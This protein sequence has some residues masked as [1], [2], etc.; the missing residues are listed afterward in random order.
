[1][2]QTQKRFI[3][4]L[5]VCVMT[6][7]NFPAAAFAEGLEAPAA[8]GAETLEAVIGS[9]GQA[10]GQDGSDTA[11][12]GAA[13]LPDEDEEDDEFTP[14]GDDKPLVLNAQALAVGVGQTAEL[15]IVDG[16]YG[17]AMLGIS[18]EATGRAVAV[19]ASEENPLSCQIRGVEPGQ[20]TV[21]VTAGELTATCTVTVT[22]DQEEEPSAGGDGGSG[23]TTGGGVTAPPDEE[24]DPGFTPGEDQKPL[25]LDH[26]ELALS[27]GEEAELNVVDGPYGVAAMGIAFESSN[28]DVAVAA[29]SEENPLSAKIRGIAEGRAVITVTAGKLS[30]QCTV[31]VEPANL[32]AD[33]LLEGENHA[34]Y[35]LLQHYKG[36][37]PDSYYSIAALGMLGEDL[38][39]Y[40]LS[41]FAPDVNP[42]SMPLQDANAI[43]RVLA[44]GKNPR[45]YRNTDMVGA[46]QKK[47]NLDTGEMMKGVSINSNMI[48]YLA[49]EVS[50]A[51]YN[52][53]LA[54]SYMQNFIE[55]DGSIDERPDA[56][57]LAYLVLSH[58][59]PSKLVGEALAGLKGYLEELGRQP[60]AVDTFEDHVEAVY[61]LANAGISPDIYRSTLEKLL[62][63]QLADGSFP[64]SPILG[65]PNA[66][67]TGKIAYTLAAYRTGETIFDYLRSNNDRY[68]GQSIKEEDQKAIDKLMGFYSGKGLSHWQ[69][70]VGMAAQAKGAVSGYSLDQ[71][72]AEIGN[73]RT[74]TEQ[75]QAILALS[76]IGERVSNR[77]G[78]LTSDLE[79]RQK[80]D[81]SFG[82]EEETLWAVIALQAA[83][84]VFDQAGALK[85]MKDEFERGGKKRDSR[86]QALYV[87]AFN[88]V[89]PKAMQAEIASG[90]AA[91][92]DEAQ[93]GA[94]DM[95][96]LFLMA[97]AFLL[98][99]SSAADYRTAMQRIRD[100]QLASDGSFAQPGKQETSLLASGLALAA[101]ADLCNDRSVF[102]KLE[103]LTGA[104]K[105]NTLTKALEKFDIY[106]QSKAQYSSTDSLGLWSEIAAIQANGEMPGAYS[107]NNFTD[108]IRELK[109]SQ[110][111]D[112]LAQAVLGLVAMG[113]NP[114]DYWYTAMIN[115]VLIRGN[116]DFCQLLCQLQDKETGSFGDA[117]STA[118][119]LLALEIIDAL[120]ERANSGDESPYT[121]NKELALTYIKGN[122]QAD[123][124]VET[125]WILMALAA[126]KPK[127]AKIPELQKALI[128]MADSLKSNN[129]AA[130]LAVLALASSKAD[131]TSFRY[132]VDA[133]ISTQSAE[134]SI[135]AGGGSMAANS[136]ATAIT[137]LALLSMVKNANP[138][139]DLRDRYHGIYDSAGALTDAATAIGWAVDSYNDYKKGGHFML[140]SNAVLALFAAGQDLD[141]YSVSPL[142]KKAVTP[143]SVTGSGEKRG[144][145][146]ASDGKVIL[147]ALAAGKNP[148]A[149]RVDDYVNDGT[150]E[151]IEPETARTVDWVSILAK[152][153]GRDGSFI[154][155][156]IKPEEGAAHQAWAMLALEIMG[157]SYDRDKALSVLLSL[158]NDNG[159]F[160][161]VSRYSTS[162]PN[163]DGTYSPVMVDAPPVEETSVALAVLSLGRF[164]DKAG[165]S[166]AIDMAK[167]YLLASDALQDPWKMG[168]VLLGLSGVK[169]GFAQDEKTKADQIV[170][171]LIKYQIVEGADKGQ[172]KSTW[173]YD[174]PAELGGG[175]QEGV[176][177]LGYEP[178]TAVALLGL[179]AIQSDSDA[180]IWTRLSD[181]A[182]ALKLGAEIQKA[183][184]G[185]KGYLADKLKASAQ[186]YIGILAAK[187]AGLDFAV[188]KGE[189]VTDKTTPLADAVNIL[190]LL[191]AG[192]NPKDYAQNGGSV[193]LVKLLAEKQ[194]AGGLMTQNA[195]T[196]QDIMANLLCLTVFNITQARY[197]DF[198]LPKLEEAVKGLQK[199][200]GSLGAGAE[201][202]A[203]A[204]IA[205]LTG[206]SLLME[207]FRMN[208]LDG[209]RQGTISGAS[210]KERALLASALLF[211][212][213]E[214]DA[215][216]YGDPVQKLL[217]AYQE[218]DG[219]LSDGTAAQGDAVSSVYGL[220]L[221]SEKA[222][223]KSAWREM[224]ENY[225][226]QY[227]AVQ[228]PLEIDEAIQNTLAYYAANK[229]LAFSG[230]GAL[231]LWR[232]EPDQMLAGYNVVKPWEKSQPVTTTSQVGG[233]AANIL[234]AIVMGL[235]PATL[236]VKDGGTDWLDNLAKK[237]ITTKDAWD[238]VIS[239][240]VG[241]SSGSDE[242]GFSTDHFDAM[243]ALAAGKTGSPGNKYPAYYSEERAVSYIDYAKNKGA[244][245]QDAYKAALGYIAL[246]LCTEYSDYSAENKAKYDKLKASMLET[247]RAS[248]RDSAYSMI[249]VA[250]IYIISEAVL[251]A[252]PDDAK[253]LKYLADRLT[254]F[255]IRDGKKKGQFASYLGSDGKPEEDSFTEHER[256]TNKAVLALCDIKAK[257]SVFSALGQKYK[258]NLQ[259]T[260]PRPVILGADKELAVAVG[261]KL[262][263]KAGVT[264]WSDDKKTTD[265]TD[266]MKVTHNAPATG[267]GVALMPGNYT[268]RYVVTNANNKTAVVVRNIT[269]TDGSVDLAPTI[270][271]Q[272]LAVFV[273]DSAEK[274]LGAVVAYDDED[275]KNVPVTWSI[276]EN[277][278]GRETDEDVTATVVADGLFAQEGNYTVVYAASDSK[279]QKTERKVS[280]AIQ[281]A[282]ANGAP[283]LKLKDYGFYN[284][285]LVVKDN[286]EYDPWRDLS[287]I[288]REDG[289]IGLSGVTLTMDGEIVARGSM[290]SPARGDHR[291]VYAAVDKDGVRGTLTVKMKAVDNDDSYPVRVLDRTLNAAVH[292]A[293]ELNP[294]AELTR[295]HIRRLT[296]VTL[297]FTSQVTADL[298]G[299]EYAENLTTLFIPFSPILT[300]EPLRDCKKLQIVEIMGSK[301]ASLEPLRNSTGLLAVA[302]KATRISDLS[303]LAE[304]KDMQELYISGTRVDNI[305]A[306]RNMSK[307]RFLQMNELGVTSCDSLRG[308]TDMIQ[309][310]MGQ[311]KIKDL[312]PLKDM[313]N[314]ESLYAAHGL[315]ENTD[316]LAGMTKLTSLDMEDNRITNINGLK[317]LTNLKSAELSYNAISDLSPLAGSGARVAAGRQVV[318]LGRISLDNGS[319]VIELG[320][321]GVPEVKSLYGTTVPVSSVS[322]GGGAVNGRVITW[323]NVKPGTNL[324]IKF[325]S[326]SQFD[327]TMNAV[328]SGA[329]LPEIT[330]QVTLSGRPQVGNV[331]TAVVTGSDA[332]IFSYEWIRVKDQAE[333]TVKEAGSAY[334]LADAD[335]GAEIYVKVTAAGTGGFLQSGKIGPVT[336]A[337]S[338]TE[339]KD[340][341]GLKAISQKLDGSYKLTADIAI[342]SADNWTPLGDK[343]NPFVG[344]LDGNGHTIRL[345]Y[346]GTA[347]MAVFGNI[348][349]I[350]EKVDGEDK[351][352]EG[353]GIVRN[354][355]VT[356]SVIS[357]GT[358]ALLAVK[359]FG[360]IEN[361][362]ASGSVKVTGFVDDGALLAAINN[363]YTGKINNCWTAGTVEVGKYG[364]RFPVSSNS[365]SLAN[366]YYDKDK[367]GEVE[368]GTAGAGMATAEMQSQD[369]AD[370]LNANRGDGAE[371][372]WTAGQYPALASQQGGEPQ[373][374]AG[375]IEIKDLA[376][377]KAI[378]QKLDGSY[379]LTADISI[380]ESDDWSP[381][382]SGEAFTGI[383]DG[384]GHKIQLN[385]AGSH[386]YA[387]LLGNIGKDGVVK[388]LGV[389]GNL[390]SGGSQKAALLAAGNAGTIQNCYAKGNVKATGWADGGLLAAENTGSIDNCWTSGTV[391]VKSVSNKSPIAEKGGTVTNSYFDIKVFGTPEEAVEGTGMTTAEMQEQAFT[392]LLNENK[393]GGAE[394]IYTQ[395]KYPAFTVQE[396]DPQPPAG[397]TE[398]KNLD[399]LKK[400]NQK[401]DGQYKLVGDITIAVTDSWTPIGP[402]TNQM[403]TGF[404]DGNGHKIELN[405]KGD[406]SV[407]ALFGY[408]GKDGIVKNLGA[409]G[410]VESGG[411][412]MAA[413]LAAK[414]F[415][416]VQN[417]YANGTVK[418]TGY[419]D[420]GLLIANNNQY[421]EEPG[422]V[423]NCWAAGTVEAKSFSDKYPIANEGGQITNCYYDSQVF[424]KVSS[425][426]AGTGKTTE[427]MESEGFAGL[428]N[429]NRGNGKEWVYTKGHYPAFTSQEGGDPQPPTPPAPSDVTEIRDLAGLKA[430]AQKLDGNY[431]LTA[432]IAITAADGWQ[433]IGSGIFSGFK[434]VLDGN[435]HEI[436]LDYEEAGQRAGLFGVI[437]AKGVVKNLGITGKVKGGAYAAG[438][439]AGIN[440]GTI[441]NCYVRGSVETAKSGALL[442]GT[443]S[444]EGTIDNCYVAG[445]VTAEKSAPVAVMANAV[446]VT[447]TYYDSQAYGSAPAEVYGAAKTTAEMQSKDFADLLNANRGGETAWIYTQG[448]YP[449]FGGQGGE[450]E[451]PALAGTVSI[452]GTAQEGQTLTAGISGGNGKSYAY[453]WIRVKEGKET[454]VS[455]AGNTY[456]LGRA[457][458]GAEIYVKV[459]A[460][461]ATGFIQS[462]KLGP[463]IAGE[464]SGVT[465]IRDLAGLKAMAQK[466]DGNYKLTADIGVSLEDNWMPIG[467]ESASFV[468]VLD[469]NGHTITLNYDGGQFGNQGKA[470]LFSC[471]GEAGEVKNLGLEGT[472]QSG[473]GY[474]AMLAG[475]NGGTIRNCFVRGSVEGRGAMAALAALVA[476]NT[477]SGTVDN[478]YAVGT[479]TVPGNNYFAKA[480]PVANPLGTVNGCYYDSEVFGSDTDQAATAKTTGEMQSEGF[481]K[482]LNDNRGD[483]L[484]WTFAQGRY[485]GFGS[486]PQPPQPDKEALIKA[487]EEALPG[488]IGFSRQKLGITSWLPSALARLDGFEQEKKDVFK[489]YVELAEEKLPDML[490][491]QDRGELNITDLE[492]IAI[493]LAAAGADPSAYGKDGRN[494]IE[495]IYNPGKRG[496][497]GEDAISF[498]GI[499]AV[500]YALIALD[501]R[502]Y[503]IP[504]DAAWSR[505]KLID[506]ILD[507]QIKGGGWSY[508]DDY[509]DADM[510]GMVLTALAPYGA[511]VKVKE[512]VDK[513]ALVLSG[514]QKPSGAFVSGNGTLENA[515]S[516]AQALLGLAANGID[517]ASAEFTK[518]GKTVIDA[519]LVFK[520]ENGFVHSA[521]GDVNLMIT[522]QALQAVEQALLYLNGDKGSIYQYGPLSGETAAKLG[523]LLDEVKALVQGSYSDKSWTVLQQAIKAA[524]GA[525]NPPAEEAVLK[526]HIQAI[527]KAVEGLTL[528]LFEMT[529]GE[530]TDA[531]NGKTANLQVKVENAASETGKTT[532]IAVLYNRAGRR[533]MAAYHS[534]EVTVL[535]GQAVDF[536]WSVDIPKDGDYEIQVFAWDDLSGLNPLGSPISIAV[537]E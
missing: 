293:L 71:L 91:L 468:G 151:E 74:V 404:F 233:D 296:R 485:P 384:N 189:A 120:G 388:N 508:S 210:T 181:K 477:K 208:L 68:I 447:N 336:G 473:G 320:K 340:L 110:D 197:Q 532:V 386:A 349:P 201:A 11:G 255:Q 129:E 489:K 463:V 304:M 92:D 359:N 164:K 13:M 18:F 458:L 152:K 393:G 159:S 102:R 317:N 272:D 394:W 196:P 107:L 2:K 37:S 351:P 105:K 51:D 85:W 228:A 191:A 470:G 185:V 428:M 108:K 17:V 158:K 334:T 29:P 244:F 475:S 450:P 126:I 453:E 44:M 215:E 420:G 72:K 288:D 517:P 337:I 303:P 146:P 383:L 49:L 125:A 505:E 503:S 294:N 500:T 433:A 111:V 205:S 285:E 283:V 466:L 346:E 154:P 221:L 21:T 160:G 436:S 3:A 395:G 323:S 446:K 155:A 209:V 525:L 70:A 157:A 109:N 421:I 459:T 268:A 178:V 364:D 499:N 55:K 341:A 25:A 235:D 530:I 20:A 449:G 245:K 486:Q 425:N 343:D 452:S 298:S 33:T 511:N 137:Y 491:K 516:T 353:T 277:K 429:E 292:S 172:F 257:Q 254:L 307:L 443:I 402:T 176:S 534:Q 448:R 117:A 180:L 451:K 488:A 333:T 132:I 289:V 274:T 405:Y 406:A 229:G 96:T 311:N 417:C 366:V 250:D 230:Q 529:E 236:A 226:K 360:T 309:L 392:D 183:Y 93:E 375:V 264:A 478:C 14:G 335:L 457:D 510:T 81:G 161:K 134:G 331:L 6:L 26:N 19:T 535:K 409:A 83:G 310:Q 263:L 114:K 99:E 12:G 412:Q 203:Y 63:Y 94:S 119:A 305:D 80:N 367:F 322:P 97:E 399:D 128:N 42:Y 431:K 411:G 78:D 241:G 291:L 287:V 270:F 260:S 204:I 234:Q 82:G 269:I 41:S 482:L 218:K 65:S 147:S 10:P 281:A 239:G 133:L 200:N 276:F 179:A 513:A 348:A 415:G 476:I 357:G 422:K 177:T 144:S 299:L 232:V 46:L 207:G 370:L 24:D 326:G 408:I 212:G 354:L 251:M 373:P 501:T 434:G 167:G 519:L 378:S 321:G 347:S 418:I 187:M 190:N 496:S 515:G 89:S 118:Q 390:R 527:G 537:K 490:D 280:L 442:A 492:R 39:Q 403:F 278:D 302:A 242:P 113:E 53:D 376:G 497:Q 127:D 374:P 312:S 531:Q 217:D 202:D 54:F 371:W 465:E 38:D 522:D 1:M 100:A 30:A 238:G 227:G 4:L 106:Y 279:G 290:I 175:E 533:Q 301:V 150:V 427:E 130:S 358:A 316:M 259:D 479:A 66:I 483:G 493:N 494:L 398:I 15:S 58:Y 396:S 344:V 192:E 45:N 153:Q 536:Q 313:V 507:A 62:T 265:L 76:A 474:A 345:E 98:S 435:G 61:A 284:G 445:T 387:G 419:A 416:T 222:S 216:K 382:G 400:I 369:F 401:L 139:E 397:F 524:E 456:T 182:A 73:A 342:A 249:S 123:N 424:G 319:A 514:I 193:D 330:G 223:E 48:C 410:A 389:T 5:L 237:Q 173:K 464:P 194:Q 206:G 27:M 518:N 324:Q 432:D 143:Y 50:N 87:I 407:V 512:A 462:E 273:G 75:A 64:F 57:A 22:G 34:L 115:G 338:V 275:Q 444:G 220:L 441:Q 282:Q 169:N 166:G 356:G 339:I 171:A 36:Q 140:R 504:Q 520:R 329:P 318:D 16:P 9:D 247:F 523:V 372:S 156:D 526:G 440:Q 487:L 426:A 498:Q 52:R 23:A 148:Y 361:C 455:T 31:R 472:V 332:T 77:T 142:S 124:A 252:S 379:K 350:T 414:N 219:S 188:G 224:A 186:D 88:L 480:Y 145:S 461:E 467:T 162:K 116:I 256:G 67:K 213:L 101:L 90:L 60:F 481:A 103:E 104:S 32:P 135:P 163:G 430:M 79:A 266:E 122:M 211:A 502:D 28:P 35:M 199:P 7:G 460:E 86:T 136:Q 437:N 271:A 391:E 362:Y 286:Q 327:V 454:T 112:A 380:I 484:A 246:S 325:K 174:L 315:A 131:K 300:L 8:S 469:G 267:N 261:Q 308:K 59:Q 381:I 69:E 521:D 40:N 262:D 328:A 314:L 84:A 47:Q 170:S 248:I 365:G 240:K 377:L 149:Y 198:D 195:A 363:K 471:I 295:G 253:T 168:Q 297:D 413:L 43:M 439:L 225:R 243:I 306:L 56:S 355:G 352:A 495:R 423:D 509:P 368:E 95:E 258:D 121:Y 385:Y 138:F 214:P 438:M 184:A 141:L 528:G 506:F 231:A 165:V